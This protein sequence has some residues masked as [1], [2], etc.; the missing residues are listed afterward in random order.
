MGDAQISVKH[1]FI[2]NT[3]KHLTK[4]R[5]SLGAGS[6]EQ[7]PVPWGGPE[8]VWPV[9]LVPY[10]KSCTLHHFMTRALVFGTIS[11]V[12]PTAWGPELEK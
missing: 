9:S 11:P 6:K 7:M 2:N 1:Y 4:T 8:P 10:P 3:Q 5:K 12:R